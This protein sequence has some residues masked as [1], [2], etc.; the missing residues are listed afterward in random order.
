MS[1][2]MVDHL[3]CRCEDEDEKLLK[4]A[5]RSNAS[6]SKTSTRMII[7]PVVEDKFEFYPLAFH[8]LHDCNRQFRTK[9]LIKRR[10]AKK[11]FVASR[12]SCPTKVGWYS[13]SHDAASAMT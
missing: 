1:M 5:W 8:S 12:G 9:A 10:I 3:H 4:N 11:L 13:S 6:R 7:L 2:Y